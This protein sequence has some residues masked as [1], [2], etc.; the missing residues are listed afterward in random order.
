MGAT[1][2]IEVHRALDR[3]RDIHHEDHAAALAEAIRCHEIA[4]GL[5][6]PAL[7]CRALV[8]QAAVML[9]RGDLQ[10]AVALTTDAEPYAE[11]ADDDAARAELAAVNGQLHFFAGSYPESLAQAELAIALSDRV[12]RLPLRVFT[13]RCACVVFGNIGV[14]DWHGKLEEVLALAIEAG[15]AWE[16][17]M[18]RNDLAHLT[19]ER[20]DLDEAERMLAV[21][22][23]TAAPLA[24]RNTFALA[25]LRCTRSEVRL[26]AGRAEEALTD[27][28]HAVDLLTADGEP[29][30]YLLAMSV[31]VEVRAL[32]ALGRLDEAERTGQRAVE[33]LGDRV[34][35]ARSMIL[36]TVAEALREAGRLEQAYDVLSASLAVE[37]AAFAELSALRRGLERATLEANAAR[38]QADRDW[39]TGLH[40][41]RYLARELGRHAAAPGPFSLAMLDLDHFKAINDRY[42]HHAGDQVLMRIAALLLGGVRGQDVVVRTGGEEFMLLMPETDAPA[43]AAA[44][45][46]LRNAIR[47]EPWDHIAGDLSITAS[48]GLATAPVAAD[49]AALAEIADQRLY[50]AKRSGRDRVIAERHVYPMGQ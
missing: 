17:A 20:G 18:S 22:M 14:S 7:R 13:R 15:N 50:A 40:N 4:R 31:V 27:A 3:A 26:R 33:R 45:E 2:A 25:V 34:P 8:L 49:L 42:G 37:R 43:A 28:E 21:A 5:D 41:R 38:D 16:E 44:C 32:L 6:E 35:Q 39:L 36:S 29:N 30:P 9:Q 24:P 19:M 12:D 47:D 46:R 11:A 48:F 1:A 23:A 10:G